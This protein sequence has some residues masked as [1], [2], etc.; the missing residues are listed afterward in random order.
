VYTVCSM[1]AICSFRSR[2]HARLSSACEPHF[3]PAGSGVQRDQALLWGKLTNVGHQFVCRFY[4]QEWEQKARNRAFA[5]CSRAALTSPAT[6]ASGLLGNR[7][8][9]FRFG[10]AVAAISSTIF[11]LYATGA[12]ASCSACC[13]IFNFDLIYFPSSYQARCDAWLDAWSHAQIK[14]W[15]LC[16][17]AR[18]QPGLA[19]SARPLSAAL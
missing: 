3:A 12:K 13:I 10:A 11:I 9:S 6:Q 1:F 2:A 14:R 8:I 4:R 15:P 17:C 5:N 19:R 16:D 18:R 7:V